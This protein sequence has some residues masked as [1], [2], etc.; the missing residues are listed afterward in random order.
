MERNY[1]TRTPIAGNV[2]YAITQEGKRLLYRFELEL[3]AIV[4]QRILKY[5]NGIS[6]L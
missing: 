4:A 6:D 2:V 1:I 5:G 3:D